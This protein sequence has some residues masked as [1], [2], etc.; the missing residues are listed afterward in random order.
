[1]KIST[2]LKWVCIAVIVLI[3]VALVIIAGSILYPPRVYFLSGDK[4]VM[5]NGFALGLGLG[6]CHDNFGNLITAPSISTNGQI[7]LPGVTTVKCISH[8]GSTIIAN[9]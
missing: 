3:L 2:V 8:F 9:K 5:N 7:S 6:N 1:M 4:W